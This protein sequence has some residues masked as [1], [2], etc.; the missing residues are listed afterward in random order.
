MHYNFNFDLLRPGILEADRLS[1]QLID[2]IA[3]NEYTVVLTGTI[4]NP[5]S[6]FWEYPIREWSGTETVFEMVFAHLAP[7]MGELDFYFAPP[8]T[9]PVLGQAV[10]TLTN[11]ARLPILEFEEALYE[12]I[13][14]PKDD[15]ATIV[16][17][18]AA[19]V[20]IAQSRGTIAVFDADPTLTGNVGVNF[21][22]QSG[23]SSVLADVNFP[24]RT[25]TYH[26]AFGTENF[27]GYFD[28]DFTSTIYADIGFQELSSYADVPQVVTLV[29]LTPVGNS[30]AVIHEADVTF[31]A[32]TKSNVVLAGLP[33]S[34][35]F[36]FLVNNGRPVETFPIIRILNASLTTEILDVYLL[37]PGTPIEDAIIPQISR[38]PS[39][40]DTGFSAT[41]EGMLELTITL[42]GE[43]TPIAAPVILDLA[44]GDTVD[45][46]IVDTVNPGM[47]ELAIVDFQAAP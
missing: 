47:V 6:F 35:L 44:N 8:G 2:V 30:G 29:T 1:T 46:V 45:T 13:L 10:G 39:L 32:S 36:L 40:S 3:D 21:I 11:G 7:S 18:S 42:A 24:P 9:V 4:A 38:I 26:A 19:L 31:S 34:P 28:S 5:S 20:P 17:Q 33:G 22:A 12:L 43:T 15:P 27:D 41:S 25:R 16:Y 37:P 14:T 23:G